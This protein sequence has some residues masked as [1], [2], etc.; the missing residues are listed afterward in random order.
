MPYGQLRSSALAGAGR[1][2]EA[3]AAATD[4]IAAEPGEPEPLFNR[5]LALAG[6]E[7][8]AEAADDY[9]RALRMDMTGSALDPDAV[10]DELFFALRSEAVRRADAAPLRRY[11]AVL[12]AG[13]HVADVPRWIDKL[14]GID[15]VWYRD[16]V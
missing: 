12:P 11:L 9:E 3:I 13:R 2:E 1:F 16:K 5:G 8:F 10:D 4:E 15:A 14:A 6:L 7:R